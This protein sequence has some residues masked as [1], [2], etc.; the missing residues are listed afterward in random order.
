MIRTM[1]LLISFIAIWFCSAGRTL[2]ADSGDLKIGV[3]RSV[4]T[5]KSNMWMAGY[6]ARKSPSDGVL[7]DLWAKALVF[8]DDAGSKT[9]IVTLDL[10]GLPAD[11][12]RE[13]AQKA[14][15]E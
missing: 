10:L 14:E 11:L 7:Q 3:G 6:A 8:S 15:S 1:R 12:S 13:I 9:A 2:L 4:I 5:P